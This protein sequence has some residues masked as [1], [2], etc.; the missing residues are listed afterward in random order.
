MGRAVVPLDVRMSRFRELLEEKQI[1]AFSTWE[2]ELHKIVFD[3]RYLLLTSKER[4]QVFDKYVRERAEEERK[5]K[6]QKA[7]ERKD[8]FKSL[9]EEALVNGRT[10]YSDFSR[11]HGKDERYKAIEKSRERESQ[12]NEFQ[13]EVRRKEK[14]EKEE[15]RKQIKK[16]FKLLLK[17]T[18]GIDRHAYWGDVKKLIQEDS[19]YKAVESSTQKEDWFMDYVHELKDE[20]RREKEKK[21]E[22]KEREKSRERSRSRSRRS[23]SRS[24]GA[25]KRSASRSRS[26]DKK[27]EKKEKRDRSRDRDV[28][29]KKKKDKDR[30]RSRSRSRSRERSSKDKKKHKKDKERR[31]GLEDGEMSEKDGEAG[32]IRSSEERGRSEDREKRKE[33]KTKNDDD[34]EDEKME[35]DEDQKKDEDDNQK[36][37]KEE[38]MLASLRKR[39]EEVKM[40]MEGHLRDRDKER[41]QH[42]HQEAVNGFSALLTD[43]IRAPDFSWKEA[44]KQLKKDSRWEVA[45]NLDKSERER[46]FDE[47]IDKLIAKKKEN[48][49]SLLDE[50]KDIGLDT[51][52]KEVKKQIRDDPRYAKF[53]SSDRKCEKEFKEWLKD[54][55]SGARSNY[56]QLLQ[57]TKIISHKSLQMIKDKE[58]NHMEEIEEI[59]SKDSRYLVMEPI[60]DDRADILMA[61]L[62]ELERRGPPPPPTASEPSRRK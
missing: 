3:P 10:S 41:V 39:E 30:S 40:E 44:K 48:F 13:I 19:R 53:S 56:R 12:F 22:R 49:R 26:R 36:K 42:Q 25:R 2:K 57:E 21:K 35:E 59:L 60:N 20:H 18:E 9:M 45:S 15:K 7:K 5:E 43:L 58:G 1:S 47:H 50:C 62:E 52:F 38:R 34:H 28:K 27:K 37:E 31:E 17:E 55:V 11:E 29:E 8:A 14:E 51:S 46:L 61:Y 6:K 33:D 16:D 24:R 4:K 32:E 54:R 23:R